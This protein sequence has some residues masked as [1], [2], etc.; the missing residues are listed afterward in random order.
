VAS[1]KVFYCDIDGGNEL[2]DEIEENVSELMSIL[3]SNCQVNLRF[4]EDDYFYGKFVSCDLDI[5]LNQE[6]NQM[7]KVLRIFLT[8]IISS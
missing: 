6:T 2:W 3:N 5:E 4:G 7:E 8:K 1:M